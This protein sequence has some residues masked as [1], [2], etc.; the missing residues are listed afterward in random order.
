MVISGAKSN[1]ET[2]TKGGDMA[3]RL[4]RAAKNRLNTLSPKHQGHIGGDPHNQDD[5]LDNFETQTKD[6]FHFAHMTDHHDEMDE[7][8]EKGGKYRADHLNRHR[9]D[10]NKQPVNGFFKFLGCCNER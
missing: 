8:Y 5:D 1:S 6:G 4:K 2:L 7:H 10:K 3:L 9:N